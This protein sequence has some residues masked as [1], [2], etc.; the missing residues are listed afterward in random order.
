MAADVSSQDDSIPNMTI[1]TDIFLI[2][3]M[4]YLTDITQ[5]AILK[6]NQIMLCSINIKTA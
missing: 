6:F 5:K 1:L 2:R 3:V 4:S